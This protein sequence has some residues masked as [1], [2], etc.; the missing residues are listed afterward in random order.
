MAGWRLLCAGDLLLWARVYR[1]SARYQYNV[2]FVLL[3][4]INMEICMMQRCGSADGCGSQV[5]LSYLTR[6]DATVS[7]KIPL[8]KQTQMYHPLSFVTRCI[9]RLVKSDR[10]DWSLYLLSFESH[11][12]LIGNCLFCFGDYWCSISPCSPLNTVGR[13]VEHEAHVGRRRRSTENNYI[14]VLLTSCLI[15]MCKRLE[16]ILPISDDLLM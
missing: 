6:F 8:K 11:R 2:V 4:T 7:A 3:E 10:S 16:P 14:N 5:A 13:A 1:G 9:V 15:R 12:F